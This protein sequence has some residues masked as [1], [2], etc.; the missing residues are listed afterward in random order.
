[1]NVVAPLP[2]QLDQIENTQCFENLD[3]EKGYHNGIDFGA[4]NEIL[5]SLVRMRGVKGNEEDGS[6]PTETNVDVDVDVDDIERFL[7]VSKGECI[8]EYDEFVEQTKNCYDNEDGV[9]VR[10]GWRI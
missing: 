4:E 2:P 7:D 1:M 5:I 10:P 3:P 8:G 9:M 6:S